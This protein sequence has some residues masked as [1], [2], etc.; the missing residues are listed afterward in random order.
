VTEVVMSP[1][2][3]T[4]VLYTP[5]IKR[6]HTL[7]SKAELLTVNQELRRIFESDNR[8][9]KSVGISGDG[10]ILALLTAAEDSEDR[11]LIL[12]KFGNNINEI[13]AVED[14]TG[15][16]LS[17]SGRYVTLASENRVRVYNTENGDRLGS[18]SLSDPVYLADYFPDDEL[19]LI[20]SG[21]Y[22]AESKIFSSSKVK[23]V[24]FM[25]GDILSKYGPASLRLHEAFSVEF[26]RNAAN[27][28]LLHGA[29]K[30]LDI[31]AAF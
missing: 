12:D 9:L 19:L 8:Y 5:K 2:R 15:I 7:G 24:S 4:V 16:R 11:V 1:G 13:A 23:V 14:L 10:N 31:T 21:R 18:T 30:E 28:Y 6:A 17:D 25:L 26:R 27:N 3:Q 20:L 29:N 22:S